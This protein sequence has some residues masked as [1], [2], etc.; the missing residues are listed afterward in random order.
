[1]ES[2]TFYRLINSH[3]IYGDQNEIKK[4]KANNADACQLPQYR[5]LLKCK[6]NNRQLKKIKKRL[7][8]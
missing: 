2:Y 4:I 1:M 6:E 7:E 8:N 5:D 3:L